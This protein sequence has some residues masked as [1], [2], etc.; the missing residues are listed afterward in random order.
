[1]VQKKGEKVAVVKCNSYNQLEIDRA[2][3]KSLDLIGFDFSVYRGKSV[4]LKPNIVSA[5]VKNPSA[6]Y[7][8]P[9]IIESLCKLL[10]KNKCKI[11]VGESSFMNTDVF[12]EKSGISKVAKKYGAKVVVFELDSLVKIKDSSAEILKEFP[13]SK[14]FKQMDLI[15]NLPKLKTHI[16]AKYT[17]GIK[18][19]FGIIPGG[20]KQRLHNTAKGE[21]DFSKL[22]VDI[23]QNIKPCL[24]IMDGVVGMEGNGPTSGS[25]KKVG[26]IL[27]SRNTVALDLAGSKIMG[28]SPKKV[29]HLVEAIKRGLYPSINFELVGMKELPIVNFKKPI[30]EGIISTVRKLFGEKPIVVDET[31]CIKC[32][33]CAKKCPAGAISL[34]P[35]PVIDKKKCIR[36]FCCMEICPQDA[37]SLKA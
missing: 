31:K 28:Y 6:T 1:M 13:V 3:K 26:L 18:N 12:F 24:N 19:L 37:L 8:Q 36:C 2:I 25:P 32:G 11:Y 20:L 27:A 23:Y 5:D 21:R 15:V 4:M 9:Q 35:Y 16:L 7:T 30:G 29:F 10:K 17:G 33:T 14:T 34:S 22:L